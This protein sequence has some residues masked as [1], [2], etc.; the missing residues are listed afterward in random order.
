MSENIITLI[1]E[2]GEE[3]LFEIILSLEAEGKDY[4]ILVPSNDEEDDDALIF[5]IDKDEKGEILV[6]IED[7]E[8]YQI[9]VDVYE[10]LMEEEGLYE[11]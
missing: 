10:T 6:P 8:E 4:A 5:R 1:D 11:E 2:N 7:D 3:S 9:V